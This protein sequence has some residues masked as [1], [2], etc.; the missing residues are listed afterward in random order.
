[1]DHPTQRQRCELAHARGRACI[2]TRQPPPPRSPRRCGPSSHS[3]TTCAGASRPPRSRCSPSLQTRL[4]M[5]SMR[6]PRTRSTACQSATSTRCSTSD[7][8]PRA[9]KGCRSRPSPRRARTRARSTTARTTRACLPATCFC[10]T[11]GCERWGYASDVT[12]TWPVSGK[13]SPAQR[14]VYEAV[15]HAHRACLA[16]VRPGALLRD[17]H[18]LSVHLLTDALEDLGVAAGA[19]GWGG[20]D[21]YRRHYPHAV[22]HWLG[23]DTH[24]CASVSHDMPLV[25]GV[26]LTIEPGLYLRG[27]GVP[28]EL[29]GIG[30]RIEDD[31]AVT[32][33]GCKVLSTAAPMDVAAVEALAGSAAEQWRALS[34]R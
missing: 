17:I 23:L 27:E 26:T 6:A 24:D 33:A 25:E 18:D 19:G 2:Q 22:G 32:A 8:Q 16:E 10:S 1:M 12:R 34:G 20:R 3:C 29:R 14:A 30:V 11:Q 31:V 4:R 15:L 7:A 5:R 9:R 21:G 28:Q 13:F